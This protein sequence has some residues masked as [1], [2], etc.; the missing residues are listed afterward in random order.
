MITTRFTKLLGCSTPIQLAGM[1][2]LTNGDLAAAVANAGAQGMISWSGM[3]ADRLVQALDALRRRTSGVFG[4]NFLIPG[5]EED[6]DEVS[7][8]VAVAAGR[9]KVVDFFYHDPV[10][11]L[12]EIVH[13]HGALACWQVGSSE[14]AAAAVEAGCDLI[15]AQGIEAGG[16]IRGT[17]GVMALLDEV[18]RKV[19]VPVLAAGGIAT[20]RQ[21]A[22]VLAAGADGARMGTRFV[23]AS[24]APTHPKYVE[25][26]ICSEARDTVYTE[27]F[28]YG[29]PN[30]PHRVLRSCVAAAQA[31]Q[32]EIVGERLSLRT[33]A[34][35]PVHRF[36]CLPV[37]SDTT[38]RVEAMPF[39]AGE[40]V[41]GVTKRQPASEI[42]REVVTD[43]ENLL[44]NLN[45]TAAGLA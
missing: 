45:S 6:P 36:E 19:R 12:V 3:P 5:F 22:A 30:A 21:L 27:A 34:R 2:A 28:C 16:H 23:V 32:G 38:G 8:C 26:L 20:G 10:P 35:A 13:R 44:S 24:E 40:S 17:I 14:E 4:V 29:W 18:L 37:T 43:A 11:A 1:G 39:W 42:V 9:A 25:A 31:F 41:S 33:G 15:V 7:R